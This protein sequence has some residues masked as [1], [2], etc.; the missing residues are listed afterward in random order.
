MCWGEGGEGGGQA[1]G[2]EWY[3]EYAATMRAHYGSRFR[4]QGEGAPATRTQG[5]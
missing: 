4:A 5:T 3:A 2:Q 1:D